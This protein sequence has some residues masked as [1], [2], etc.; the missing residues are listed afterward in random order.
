MF[1]GSV[2]ENKFNIVDISTDYVDRIRFDD[3]TNNVRCGPMRFLTCPRVRYRMTV[4]LGGR[5]T[6]EIFGIG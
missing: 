6:S 5:E 1:T 4:I 3:I 2:G